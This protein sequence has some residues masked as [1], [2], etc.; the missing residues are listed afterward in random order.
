MANDCSERVCQFGIAHVDTPKGDLNMDGK[1][2]NANVKLIR[3]S[4]VYPWGTTEQFPNGM[5]SELN[6]VSNSA[7]YYMECSNKGTCDRKAGSCACF[8]GYDGAA[9]QRA[10]CP[11]FPDSCSGHGTCRSIK[12]IAADDHSNIYEL[13]DKDSTMGCQCDKGY[14]GADCSLRS[15]KYGIDPLYLDDTATVKYSIFDFAVLTTATTIDFT[16]GTP[17]SG[18]AYFAIRFYDASGEDWL[19]QP[20]KSG[21]SCA[22]VIEA[23]EDLPNNVIP[24]GQTWCSLNTQTNALAVE[25]PYLATGAQTGWY[26]AVDA[27]TGATIKYNLA[28]W[29]QTL[30]SAYPKAGTTQ[31]YSAMTS[32]LSGF[33]Y[34]I[35]F[36]GNPG[37]L[38]QPEIEIYLD[39]KRPSISST[40]TVITK[41]WTDGQQGENNDYFADHC[42]GVTVTLQY[43]TTYANTGIGEVLGSEGTLGTSGTITTSDAAKYIHYLDGM[44]VSEMA[45]LK[46]CLADADF[47]TSNNVEVYNWDYGSKMYP[48]IIKLVRT[49]TTFYDGGYYAAIYYSSSVT[50][51]TLAGVT[52][53]FFLLNPFVPTEA[54]PTPTQYTDWEVYTTKATLGLVSN[55]SEVTFGFGENQFYFTNVSYDQ[56]MGGNDN[57]GSNPGGCNTGQGYTYG[58]GCH[59]PYDGDVKCETGDNNNYKFNYIF[60]CLNKSDLFTMLNFEYPYLN[61]QH[62]NL[63]TAEKLYQ[64]SYSHS[65]W[66]D[67]WGSGYA[68]DNTLWDNVAKMSGLTYGQSGVMLD[69]GYPLTY[70]NKNYG[71]GYYTAAGGGPDCPPSRVCASTGPRG[72]QC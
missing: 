22:E 71:N 68:S 39:G 43:S 64:K 50:Y 3:D 63:Y 24:S 8:D 5:D 1:I 35:K 2:E 55:F 23:L 45:K 62:I 29:E 52:G 19:T 13:W 10:S 66:Q 11:G 54:T 56:Y 67:A 38:R 60:H 33:I 7:H 9:C 42:D 49:T 20:I 69:R 58:Y 44:T 46:T 57:S 27:Q 59:N 31:L 40:G 15:C 72:L 21:A 61:P 28:F 30:E 47:D 25:D 65:I 37:K 41:V 36:Y 48:H 70:A 53:T 12:Q 17:L 32:K 18:V 51:S 4:E 16:D 34:R 6:I 14:F 26:S